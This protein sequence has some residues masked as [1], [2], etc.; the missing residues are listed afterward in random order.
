MDDSDKE[1]RARSFALNQGPAII[2]AVGPLVVIY[3]AVAYMLQGGYI[4]MLPLVMKPTAW[5]AFALFI[6]AFTASSLR[7]LYPGTYSRWAIKNRRYL[8]L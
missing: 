1:A 7:R 5:L 4:A 6:M 8:G 3:L 2:A